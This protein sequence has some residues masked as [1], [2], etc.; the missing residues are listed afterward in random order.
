MKVLLLTLLLSQAAQAKYEAHE[1]GTFTSVV[2]STG[3]TQNGMYHEDEDLP[4]FVHGF[5]ELR[6][7]AAPPFVPSPTP[8]P[9]PPPPPRPRPPCHSKICF[10]QE[11]LM[12]S[13]IT[14]K[15]ETPV[16]YFYADEKQ[17]V[18]VNVRFPEGIITE[19]FPGPIATFPT[20]QDPHVIGGGNTTF[21][22]DI[23]GV[24]EGRVPFAPAGNIYG[25]ARAVNSNIVTSGAETEK[26]IFYRGLGRFQPK[27]SI[28]SAKGALRLSGLAQARPQ[29]AVLVHVDTN[30]QG[31]MLALDAVKTK[32]T[33]LVSAAHI[34]QLQDHRTTSPFIVRGEQARGK[35]VDELVASGLFKDE[36]LAMVNTWENGYLKVPGL[37]L[38]YI[39]PRTEV[40]QILPLNFAPAPEKLVRSF[41][42]RMEILLDTEEYRILSQIKAEPDRFDGK[43]LGR[44]AEPILHRVRELA[45]KTESE[46]SAIMNLIDRLLK[47]A[48]VDFEAKTSVK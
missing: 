25:H 23:Q 2:D 40:D 7:E 10:G 42:G 13:Q 48:S 39:L 5:G 26:F 19:T 22:V 34:R 8:A 47:E 38:L 27:I 30:G 20:M 11:E 28:T 31:Q 32:D 6:A 24:K 29:A 33:V 21:S 18:N 41:V 17:R 3:V 44:F 12:S 9:L 14:Q 36:A 37:R 15:M 1:W 16:I 43:S 45:Q 35:L 46:N 4:Q